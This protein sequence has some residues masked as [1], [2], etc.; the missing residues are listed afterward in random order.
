MGSRV[1]VDKK[2]S[3]VLRW[4]G[5]ESFGGKKQ[6][7]FCGIEMDEASA[8]GG[9]GEVLG[10]RYFRSDKGRGIFIGQKKV[11]LIG[12]AG[13]PDVSEEKAPS[14]AQA[15][16]AI[17]T[18]R[19]VGNAVV[20]SAEAAA[21][22]LEPPKMPQ[23]E[24]AVGGNRDSEAGT[25]DSVADE[26][27]EQKIGQ[28]LKRRSSLVV[29]A[30]TADAVAAASAL[31]EGDLVNVP[32]HEALL[33]IETKAAGMDWTSVRATEEELRDMNDRAIEGFLS[34]IQVGFKGYKQTGLLFVYTLACF[35][36]KKKTLPLCSLR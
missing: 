34:S 26:A 5:K 28:L 14:V 31:L 11:K 16:R 25:D 33:A 27:R 35:R 10:I 13:P 2:G 9:D 30:T 6:N 19:G 36:S 32:E 12:S 24:A 22:E 1:A 21:E 8:D 29:A 17:T 3:G 23:T 20:A 18:N 4:V 7:I 15:S